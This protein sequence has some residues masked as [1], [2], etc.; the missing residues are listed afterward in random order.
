[1][2][3]FAPPPLLIFVMPRVLGGGLRPPFEFFGNH[4]FL[5][6]PTRGRLAAAS[7][8]RAL[9]GGCS[10]PL[11]TPLVSVAFMGEVTGVQRGS[12]RGQILCV[13]YLFVIQTRAQRSSPFHCDR[14]VIG[15]ILF[16]CHFPTVG[17]SRKPKQELSNGTNA[18]DF[19]NRFQ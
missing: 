14:L 5:V 3:G 16:H 12:F 4:N 2:G 1:M 7:G 19:C 17:V 8:L 15:K 10:P 11:R 6:P 13:W 9:R 18:F